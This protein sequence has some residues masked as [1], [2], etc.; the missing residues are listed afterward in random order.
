MPTASHIIPQAVNAIEGNTMKVRKKKVRRYARETIKCCYCISGLSQDCLS[1]INIADR[2]LLSSPAFRFLLDRS[3]VGFWTLCR[4]HLIIM[5]TVYMQ[6]ISI[7]FTKLSMDLEVSSELRITCILFVQ[8][9]ITTRSFTLRLIK[10]SLEH[11]VHLISS[12][13]NKSRS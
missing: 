3:L 5:S 7:S 11:S 12:E 6:A 13:W 9:S 1:R 8:L 10:L 4:P 2:L